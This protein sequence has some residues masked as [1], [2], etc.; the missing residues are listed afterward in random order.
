MSGKPWCHSEHDTAVCLFLGNN[1]KCC[2]SKLNIVRI[3]T[4]LDTGGLYLKTLY[5]NGCY[6]ADFSCGNSSAAIDVSSGKDVFMKRW[7]VG[8]ERGLNEVSVLSS[9]K[10]QGIPSFIDSKE[11]DGYLYLVRSWQSGVSLDEYV[12]I[13][14]QI[15]LSD[16][17]S[18]MLSLCGLLADIER[19]KG[20]FSHGDIKP[21]NVIYN[22][23]EKKISIIDFETF[24]FFEKD[25]C[26]ISGLKQSGGHTVSPVSEG[27]TAP[28]VYSGKILPESDIFS[29]G[30]VFAF[31]LGMLDFQGNIDRASF[32]R[33]HKKIS[34]VIRKCISKA[35]ERRYRNKMSLRSELLSVYTELCDTEKGENIS[36]KKTVP[37][38]CADTETQDSSF[39]SGGKTVSF[40]PRAE[41]KPEGIK[42]SGIYR[43]TIVYVAGNTCFSSE[44]SY[45]AAS[46]MGL[47]TALIESDGGIG[48]GT[49]NYF[50]S[51]QRY[52]NSSYVSESHEPFYCDLQHLY[53][54]DESK[55]I[56]RG[57]FSKNLKSE[58]LFVS[59][60]NIFS[61]LGIIDENDALPMFYWTRRT[62]DLTVISDTLNSDSMFESTMLKCADCIIVPIRPNIDEVYIK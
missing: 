46:S 8:D 4:H 52:G 43:K 12:R 44:F 55:W 27:F 61:E 59:E 5:I 38:K 34:A 18:I 30:K 19:E 53:L 32:S 42:P 1:E 28:E 17:V 7:R 37:F 49:L 45:I 16:A 25:N 33:I 24:I 57:I 13:K 56:S 21:M 36:V 50:I 31:V 29:I 48:I 58:N 14:K 35:P 60:C 54:S 10:C 2:K 51:R 40:A 20:M 11:E 15:S 26:G 62:F 47:K 9:L 6:E 39:S 22:E 41:M 23:P 3:T